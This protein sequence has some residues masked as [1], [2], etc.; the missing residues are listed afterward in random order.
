MNFFTTE[1][2]KYDKKHLSWKDGLFSGTVILLFFLL[3]QPFG[4]RDKELGLKLFLFPGYFF[5]AFLNSI[6]SFYVIRKIIAKIQTWTLKHELISFLVNLVPLVFVVH[7]YTVWMAGDMPLNLY[8]YFKLFYH[9]ACL[10]LL[11]SLLEYFYYSN[12]SADIQIEYLA[13]Q[14]KRYTEIEALPENVQIDRLVSIALESGSISLNTDNLFF[15]ESS[16][17]YLEFNMDNGNEEIKKLKKRGRLHQAE[18]DLKGYPEFTRCHRAFIVNLKK[19]VQIEGNSKN[20]SLI[21]ENK[22][23][24][25][26]VSR[27]N[28]K[29]LKEKMEQII[30]S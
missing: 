29:V 20:A 11:I 5:I 13:S 8:W 9:I 12:K 23:H 19:A 21:L 28:F 10:S 15:I 4:F 2:C 16:G 3:F 22:L 26:P 17:N 25:I 6:V 1:Y 27:A 30:A 7:L 24:E 14:I 18:S